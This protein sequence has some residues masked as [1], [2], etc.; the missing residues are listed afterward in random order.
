MTSSNEL[1]SDRITKV[2]NRASLF[3]NQSLGIF[4]VMYGSTDGSD[5][6]GMARWDASEFQSGK[7]TKGHRVSHQ[8][9]TRCNVCPIG[10]KVRYTCAPYSMA[11][12]QLLIQ[13]SCTNNTHQYYHATKT[14]GIES[15]R[16]CCHSPTSCRWNRCLHFMASTET[17]YEGFLGDVNC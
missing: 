3:G 7:L 14:I 1:R 12:Q 11:N 15:C 4:P 8:S 16:R 5:I 17:E 10:S 6:S 2:H 13:Y 9:C